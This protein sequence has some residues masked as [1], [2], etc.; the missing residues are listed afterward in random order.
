LSVFYL[1]LLPHDGSI[2]FIQYSVFGLQLINW[3]GRVTWFHKFKRTERRVQ[4]ERH[5]AKSRTAANAIR[6]DCSDRVRLLDTWLTEW[7]PY[8]L[9]E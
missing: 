3:S 1:F 9:H 6:A 4:L 8:H 5:R 2:K 7:A